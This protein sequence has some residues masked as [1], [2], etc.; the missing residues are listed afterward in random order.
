MV[1]SEWRAVYLTKFIRRLRGGSQAILAE[2]SDGLCYVVKFS[3]NP[4][5]PNLLFNE[6]VGTELYGALGLDVPAWRPVEVRG[7]FLRQYPECWIQMEEGVKEP[8]SGVCF[9]SRYLGGPDVSLYEIL[10]SNR[11]N[12]VQNLRDFW[13]AW[14]IDICAE[15]ADNR[16]AIYRREAGGCL[17]AVFVDHGYLFGGPSGEK[18]SHFV[19]SRYLDSR[20]YLPLGSS[21]LLLLQNAVHNIDAN[22]VFHRAK[23]IP[24]EWQSESGFRKL[25]ACLDRL[26]NRR[27]LQSVLDAMMDSLRQSIEHDQSEFLYGFKP[28]RSVLLSQIRASRLAG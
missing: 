10:P 5:G 15:H 4:Q 6:S 13:L 21:S 22:Q 17:R 24:S 12:A 16:Q 18:R 8:E 11:F 26:S 2:A 25:A 1:T 3:N 19:T 27:L 9:A 23:T 14:L 20:V 7:S 28:T